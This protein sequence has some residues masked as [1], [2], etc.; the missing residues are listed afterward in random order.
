VAYFQ[1]VLG[2]ADPAPPCV[3]NTF[4]YIAYVN[5]TD[6]TSNTGFGIG[7]LL[8]TPAWMMHHSWDDT[9]PDASPI[10]SGTPLSDPYEITIPVLLQFLDRTANLVARKS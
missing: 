5:G 10:P 2:L 7:Y 3:S 1:H 9:P 4:D 6:S 8:S